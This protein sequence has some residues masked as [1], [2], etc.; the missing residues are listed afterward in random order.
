MHGFHD[1]W[2]F[3]GV[4]VFIFLI[5][6]ITG[7]PVHPLAFSGPTLAQPQELGGGT[8]LSLPRA[9]FAVGE[10]T[11]V[12]LP[13]SSSNSGNTYSLDQTPAFV[14]NTAF[15]DVS[16]YRG[17]ISIN[18]YISGAGSLDP[19]NEFFEMFVPQT[20]SSPV[21]ISAWILKSEA[22]GNALTIPRGT[23][24]PL[25]GTINTVQDIVLLP[26]TK[27]LVIS[28]K[29]PI[30]ASFR[31]NK[32]IGYFSTFQS[33]SPALPQNCPLPS[34]ELERFYGTGYIRDTSCIEYVNRLP[35]CQAVLTPPS[36]LSSSCQS[37]LL[38]HMNY[39][40]C[41][42]IHQRDS[43]FLG[44]TWRVYLGRSSSMWRQQHEAIKILDNTGKTV[45]AF[46][47]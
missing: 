2:F 20:A 32:C 3:V 13:G 31:E 41:V 1:S 18:H 6:I 26:G 47:Y 16:P 33:F 12:S 37:F 4:F 38:T 15:G 24:V 11:T 19:R 7:G 39:N 35:R 14:G 22:T 28:G 36:N 34:D 29:S 42:N 45:D 27:A 9:P 40:G 30:G 23:E 44:S 21:D 46:R 5:W 10:G 8:Y 25:S 43:D 17:L